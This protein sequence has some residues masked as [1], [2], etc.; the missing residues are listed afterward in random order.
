ML[1]I[2]FMVHLDILVFHLELL[3]SVIFTLESP[4]KLN[5]AMYTFVFPCC[6]HLIVI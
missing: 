5:L 6:I 2:L 3:P 1:L 4:F